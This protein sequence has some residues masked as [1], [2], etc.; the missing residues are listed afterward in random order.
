M[1][2]LLEGMP[3]TGKTTIAKRLSKLTG[4]KYI[5][6]VISQTDF[7]NEIRKIRS[8]KMDKELELLFMADLFLDELKINKLLRKES[9][10]RDKS[11][12]ASIGHLQTH[13][14]ANKNQNV[15]NA[16]KSGYEQLKYYATM[17][18]LVVH[19]KY[20]EIKIRQNLG[21]KNDLSEIDLELLNDFDIYE[22]QDEEILKSLYSLY[23]RKKV[24]II[25][26]FS[27]SVD[28]ICQK[29][30]KEYKERLDV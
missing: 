1:Y 15:I 12:N 7:G 8:E 19:L 27:G 30:L 2:I 18:E 26:C 21:G 13:G 22:K 3:G 20:N 6:S 29:I 10:V 25:E 4:C 23:G 28:E 24:M 17:P 16:I 5:K 14:F 11:F 9:I